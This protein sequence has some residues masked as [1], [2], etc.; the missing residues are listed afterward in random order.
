MAG[1]VVM[2]SKRIAIFSA[3][4]LPYLGGVEKFTEGLSGA[5]ADAGHSVTIVTNN[6]FNLSSKEKLRDGVDLVRLPCFPL[7]RGRLPI[8]KPSGEFL[9]LWEEISCIKFDGVLINA[10]FYAHTLLGLFLARKSG[11]TPVV[12]DHGS[13]HLT[14]GNP[15]LDL[16]V[17]LYE[18]G[19]TAIVKSFGPMFYGISD[20]SVEWLQH[21]NINAE[22]VIPNSIDAVHFRT[23]A[24]KRSFRDELGIGPDF[25]LAFTGRFVPEKGISA[26]LG[27]MSALKGSAVQLVMAGDGPLLDA[28]LSSGLANIH[29]V[30]RLSSEDIA[31]LLIECDL[32]CLP[33]RSE[34]FCTSLL[35]ASSCGTPSL[36]TDVGGARELIPDSSFGFIVGSADSLIITEIIND[37]VHGVYDLQAMGDKARRLVEGSYSWESVALLALD[38]LDN[39]CLSR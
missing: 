1:A 6:T 7:L 15:V 31:A 33:S 22:G 11:L 4:Y 28:I 5:L 26:L 39:S 36:V 8:P 17:R 23:S 32:F 20:K 21:F 9:A 25:M 29:V 38:A 13:A 3:N 35:E 24:S 16:F 2:K 10:R 18:H 34:G 14:F 12:L 30:G 19:V 27:M 37:A